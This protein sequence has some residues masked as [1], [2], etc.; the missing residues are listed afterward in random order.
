MTTFAKELHIYRLASGDGERDLSA[1][2]QSAEWTVSR[3]GGIGDATIIVKGTPD[4]MAVPR[5]SKVKIALS[6]GG[7]DAWMGVV[8]D[9]QP[10]GDTT[11][12]LTCR[13]W[14][15][16]FLSQVK[17]V[18]RYTDTTVGAIVTDLIDTYVKGTHYPPYDQ[19]SA[20]SYASDYIDV[21]NEPVSDFTLDGRVTLWQAFKQLAD[22][23]DS[24]F[25]VYADGWLYFKDQT[26]SSHTT[27]RIADGGVTDPV[28]RYGAHWNR[29]TVRGGN[30]NRWRPFKYTYEDRGD[31]AKYG[32]REHP[33]LRAPWLRR[34]ND[35]RRWCQR[36][37]AKHGAQNTI[38]TATDTEHDPD[39]IF[40]IH[41]GYVYLRDA[42][43]VYVVKDRVNEYRVSLTDHYRITYDFGYGDTELQ[44][45]LEQYIQINE[46]RTQSDSAFSV[47]LD[48]RDNPSYDPI[49]TADPRDTDSNNVI[50]RGWANDYDKEQD[51]FHEVV[52]EIWRA[53]EDANAAEFGY[54]QG[55]VDEIHTSAQEALEAIWDNNN[56]GDTT[57]ATM[58]REM[59]E[60]TAEIQASGTVSQTIKDQLNAA[61]VDVINNALGAGGGSLAETIVNAINEGDTYI[62][63][64]ALVVAGDATS[65][66]I[67][68]DVSAPSKTRDLDDV[69]VFRSNDTVGNKVT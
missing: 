51:S 26:T 12:K 55:D 64:I 62:T 34:V 33:G 52:H 56:V 63:K 42:A 16:W 68:D 39:D 67:Q 5:Y 24:L 47:Q 17:P 59:W 66:Q 53:T 29:I 3:L 25:G 19:I 6:D 36:F 7:D 15:E 35:A 57:T 48:G 46:S 13:S 22:F 38:W 32:V 30:V 18:V 27:L 1:G 14:G 54:T 20:V 61:I 21:S 10:A 8:V 49:S 41:E 65:T 4:I 37:L 23:A 28:R 60:R 31:I 44:S 50:D 9:D 2:F 45:E 40:M 58:F 11:R 43:G 69:W